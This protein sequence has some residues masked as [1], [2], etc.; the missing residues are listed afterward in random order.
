MLPLKNNDMQVRPKKALGQHFLTDLSAARRIADSLQPDG[1][2]PENPSDV[3]EIGPG[4]GVLS[5]YLLER[6]DISLKM[7]EIDSESVD[8]LLMNFPKANGALIQAD[9]LKL[10]LS[11]FFRQDFCVIGNFPYNISSQIF[12]KILDHKDRIPQVVCMIQKEV[13]ERIAE[14]PGTKTYGILSV[15]LQAWYDIEY[16][17]TVGEGAFNPPPKVKSA[18]IRLRRND[19]KSL[20]CDESLF[21]TIVK[22]SFNQRRK[23]LRNSLKPLAAAMSERNGWSNEK[24]AEFLSAGIFDL[25]PEKLGV[26]DFIALTNLFQDSEN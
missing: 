20:G 21:K 8:Y 23:T 17:F 24:L 1:A 15:L 13:A 10:D 19:R 7:V 3:L 18:V 25:R 4:M 6:E 22:T 16:L 2:T 12:F 11:R 26:E 5:Q 14:K 9:F